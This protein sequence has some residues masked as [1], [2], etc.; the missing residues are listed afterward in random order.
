MSL[1]HALAARLQDVIPAGVEVRVVTAGV[2]VFFAGSDWGSITLGSYEDYGE[3]PAFWAERV[4][5]NVQ[6]FVIEFFTHTGWPPIDSAAPNARQH[7][8]QLPEPGAEVRGGKLHVWYGDA[9]QPSLELE[10]IALAQ[11]ESAS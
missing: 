10:P 11:F 6:D 1:E 4:L 5:D 8:A 2:G 3:D 9:A 7:A